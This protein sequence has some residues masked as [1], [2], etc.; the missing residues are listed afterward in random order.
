MKLIM[1]EKRI[2]VYSRRASDASTF[3]IS[4]ISLFPG[5]ITFSYDK[6]KNIALYNVKVALAKFIRKV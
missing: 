5:L 4:L 6:P 2:I 1:L 3:I